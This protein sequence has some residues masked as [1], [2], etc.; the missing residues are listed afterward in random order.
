MIEHIDRQKLRRIALVHQGLTKR[1]PF[2]LGLEATLRTIRHLGYVQID[3]ISVV[4][5]AHNHILRTR[6]PN[7]ENNHIERLL[8][9]RKIFENRFPVAAFRP[10]QEFRFTML[11]ARKFRSKTFSR[12]TKTL[13][14][15]VLDR[16]TS[17]GPLRSRDFEDT[18]RKSAGWWDWKPA[19]RALE[20]LYFQGDLMISARDGFQKSY[21]L[22]ERVLPSTVDVR[23]PTIEEFAN[24]LV[25]TTLRTHGFA[26]YKSFSSGARYGVPLAG[27]VKEVL[28]HRTD[29][30]DLRKITSD[31]GSQYWVKPQTLDRQPRRSAKTVQILSPFDNLVNQR[32]R[33]SEVFDFDFQL[34]CYLPEAKRRY[35]YFCLPI[36][37]ADQLAGRMDC[38]SHR[39]ESR[40]E[41]KALYLEPEF[42][43]RKRFTELVDPLSRAMVDYARFDGCHEVFVTKSTPALAKTMLTKVL[44]N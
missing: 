32:E 19:K 17:E 16:V 18:R 27:S 35:G 9:D 25:D 15:S 36:I 1:Q 13:M 6:V 29:A 28:K 33:L 8:Q 38:K 34:E 37:Y 41:I 39:D 22:I 26:T 31:G 21:D 2:G 42:A 44:G 4:L 10:I 14:K 40:F 12:N 7:V 23:E 3:T 43:S 24:F 5:R 20:Q 30:G 11:H